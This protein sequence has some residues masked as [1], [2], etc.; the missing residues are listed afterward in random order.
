MSTMQL[1]P[2]TPV[3]N[4]GFRL[5]EVPEVD[6]TNRLL[7]D[8]RRNGA[9]SGLVIRTDFQT[10][11]RGRRGRTWAAPPGSGVMMSLLLD[12]P[13]DP[14]RVHLAATV[15]GLA[16]VAACV[17]LGADVGLKWPNDVVVVDD[18]GGLAKLAGVLAE[19]VVDDGEIT[20]VVVGIGLNVRPVPDRDAE[21]GRHVAVLDRL[22]AAP[23]DV[24]ELARSILRHAWVRLERLSGDADLIREEVR[25]TSV[26]LGRR[27][28]VEQEGSVLRGLAVDIDDAG[29]L[30]VE[31]EGA[32][33]AVSV[34]DVVSAAV[35]SG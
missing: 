20:G 1:P 26:V 2:A 7:I 13:S 24:A 3:T 9:A 25:R 28:T 22:T 35:D 14:S 23:V 5:V 8:E 15:V 31:G 4:T 16:A 17:D 33:T 21:L 11:G 30:V 12:P 34:G 10:A 32:T 18:G 19:T 29:R 6:S 27:V